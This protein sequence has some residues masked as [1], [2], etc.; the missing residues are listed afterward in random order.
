MT[1]RRRQWNKHVTQEQ[2]FPDEREEI[3]LPADVSPVELAQK[4]IGHLALHMR[5]NLTIDDIAKAA[6]ALASFH[7]ILAPTLAEQ[8]PS[9]G[10]EERALLAH[11]T[12]EEL[13]T[14]AAIHERARKRMEEAESNVTPIRKKA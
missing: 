14:I 4:G 13:D 6:R 1:R 2:L 3:S 8:D 11:M 9:A 7:A 12:A 5:G 10:E